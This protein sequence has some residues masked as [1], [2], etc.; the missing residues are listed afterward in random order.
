MM[1]NYLLGVRAAMIFWITVGLIPAEAVFNAVE[2]RIEK[3][4]G[5]L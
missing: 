1:L 3:L 5:K 2:D 4:G